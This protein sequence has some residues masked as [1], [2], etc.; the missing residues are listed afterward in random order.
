METNP[1][2]TFVAG[3]GEAPKYSKP[4]THRVE[5]RQSARD[6]SKKAARKPDRKP[7]HIIAHEIMS[8][9]HSD[10]LDLVIV[11]LLQYK[12]Q[13]V[14]KGAKATLE[15]RI[16]KSVEKKEKKEKKEL[17][18]TK[19]EKIQKRREIRAKKKIC[20]K[21][22]T[23]Q[24]EGAEG[25]PAASA[26]PTL[27]APANPVVLH[28][29]SVKTHQKQTSIMPPLHP[30][31]RRFDSEG[32]MDAK[33]AGG[34]PA[35]PAKHVPIGAIVASIILIALMLVIVML[36]DVTFTNLWDWAGR[37]F[38]PAPVR[39]EAAHIFF[40]PQLNEEAEKQRHEEE[41]ASKSFVQR[42]LETLRA[43][44]KPPVQQDLETG[45][46]TI[47][48]D[49]HALLPVAQPSLFAKACI[50]IVPPKKRTTPQVDTEMAE[51]PRPS[52]PAE[53][54]I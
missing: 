19:L 41:E 30:L 39:T 35:P 29:F 8:S 16:T 46:K 32:N 10:Q 26:S 5:K 42:H 28:P 17:S 47:V 18:P 34:I 40:N 11:C 23:A 27:K 37:G 3:P 25:A 21:K 13:N 1:I 44:C 53:K 52:G 7:P 43:R 31:F 38:K 54:R 24:Q 45:V 2:L 49:V 9:I 14:S 12:E 4:R 15:S 6:K 33:S 51:R 50:R 48:P 36:P 20:A 22:K